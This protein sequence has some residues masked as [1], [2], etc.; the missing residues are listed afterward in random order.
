MILGYEFP[1]WLSLSSLTPSSHVIDR[2]DMIMVTTKSGQGR[3]LY[4][5]H[6]CGQQQT[7]NHV[8]NVCP[9]TKFG[10]GLQSLHEAS[11]DAVHWLE[12]TAATAFARWNENWQ[13]EGM[14]VKDEQ[15]RESTFCDG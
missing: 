14:V 5:L 11:D 7:M 15:C 10:G 1:E 9:F 8:V 2:H 13:T 12:F 3:C 6:K 4:N